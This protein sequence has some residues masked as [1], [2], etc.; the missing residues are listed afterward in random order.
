MEGNKKK[1]LVCGPYTCGDPALTWDVCDRT[2]TRKPPPPPKKNRWSGEERDQNVSSNHLE[3][4]WMQKHQH[5]GG[6]GYT[7]EDEGG[8]RRRSKLESVQSDR[9]RNGALWRQPLKVRS[10]PVIA[11]TGGVYT[12]RNVMS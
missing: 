11:A 2:W 8:S 7:Q 4:L 5:A 12:T 1:T 6:K 3:L 10:A 9:S